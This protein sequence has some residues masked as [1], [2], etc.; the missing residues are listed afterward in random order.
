LVL[1]T[2]YHSTSPHK[3]FRFLLPVLPIAHAYA[4]QAVSAFLTPAAAAG[5]ASSSQGGFPPQRRRRLGTAIAVALFF[6]HVPAAVY[7]SVWHQGGALAAVDAAARGGP[8]L[9]KGSDDGVAP[10]EVAVHFLMPCHSAPLHSH[11]HF[12]GSEGGVWSGKPSLW[13]LDCSPK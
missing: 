3:E 12:R 4:G 10:S 9:G 13:S 8:R 6:L 1:H 7:L 5:P 11:L 2:V